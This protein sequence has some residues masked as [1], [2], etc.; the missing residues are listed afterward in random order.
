M[1]KST[2]CKTSAID[3]TTVPPYDTSFHSVQNVEIKS[4]FQFPTRAENLKLNFALPTGKL[5]RAVY[6]MLS[7]HTVRL[8]KA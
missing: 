4:G 3:L 5:L 7:L 6:T 2:G 1:S 8:A